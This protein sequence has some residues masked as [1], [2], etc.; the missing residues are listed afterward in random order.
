MGRSMA[1]ADL[2]KHAKKKMVSTNATIFPGFR[3]SASSLGQPNAT[4]PSR[5]E[6]LLTGEGKAHGV[7][8]SGWVSRAPGQSLTTGE[9]REED[10]FERPLGKASFSG[11]R[12]LP[13]TGERG[14]VS[15][16]RTLIQDAR[17]EE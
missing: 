1:V 7:P 9:P 4:A 10:V 5:V 12:D 2:G 3:S 14:L 11:L 8:S 13:A 16:S 15:E 17:S 6:W